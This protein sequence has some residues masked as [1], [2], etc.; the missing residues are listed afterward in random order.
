MSVGD[1]TEFPGDWASPRAVPDSATAGPSR[2]STRQRIAPSIGLTVVG[3]LLLLLFDRQLA[4]I[5]ALVAAFGVAV[6]SFASDAFV[7]G[8]ATVQHRVA[9]AVGVGLTWVLLVPVHYLV[10]TPA[11]LI[12]RVLRIDTLRPASGTVGWQQRTVDHHDRPR[13]GYADE[14][15]TL[16]LEN[17]R[18]RR[19]RT[20]RVVIAILAVEAAVFGIVKLVDDRSTPTEEYQGV[21]GPGPRGSAALQN[22]EDIDATMNELGQAA[23]GGVYTPVGDQSLRNFQGQFV[24]VT[25]R[26]RHSYLTAA[27]GE[28]L[29]VWFF[30]GSTMFGFDAQREEHTIP[31]EVVRLAEAEGRPILARNYG[32]QGLT[33]FQE[34][35][36]LAQLLSAGR[37]ADLIVFYDGINDIA[38]QLQNSL[39]HRDIAGEPGQLQSD[40]VRSAIVSAGISPNNAPPSPLIEGHEPIPAGLLTVDQLVGSVVEVYGQGVG[41]ARTLTAAYGIPVLHFWQ[42]DLFTRTPLDPGEEALFESQGL[43]PLMYGTLRAFWGRVRAALPEGVIDVA[44]VYDSIEG[45]ILSDVVHANEVGALAVATA[46]YPAISGSLDAVPA[47]P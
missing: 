47:S 13:R 36:I 38:L 23:S 19:A 22:Q 10:L 7:R 41:L 5:I 12:A 35:Q 1:Q 42:P 39:A 8:F 18:D 28:P 14:R 25:N 3:L 44:S 11:G 17:R 29:E 6:A 37:R 4:A 26:E 15:S 9:H 20:I 31:S 2:P 45:P 27:P 32:A 34:T 30:G 46:M 21:S 16:G 40:L 24:N 33:N 43:D